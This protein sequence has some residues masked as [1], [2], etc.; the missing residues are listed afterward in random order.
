MSTRNWNVLLESFVPMVLFKTA[1]F[2]SLSTRIQR[3]VVVVDVD[4]HALY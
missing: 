3:Y 1:M 4:A 2:I